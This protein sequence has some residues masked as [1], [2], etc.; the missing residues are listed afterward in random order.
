MSLA[1]PTAVLPVTLSA[2]DDC[3]ISQL[4][5]FR[6]LNDSR[7][8]ADRSAACRRIRPAGSTNRSACRWTSYGLEPGD[9]IKL[10][11]RVEDNDPAG[12]KGA[13]SSVVIVRIVSQEEFEQMIRTRQGIEAMLSKYYAA[14]RRMEAMAKEMD[15]LRRN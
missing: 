1:T 9:V 3:G 11:G 4:Q 12:A 10:F 13:E 5:L 15:G 7:P 8:A 6:S 2:E 14:R